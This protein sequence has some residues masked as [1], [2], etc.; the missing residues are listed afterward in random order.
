[1]TDTPQAQD[2]HPYMQR[3]WLRMTAQ[4]LGMAALCGFVVGVLNGGADG[5][6]YGILGAASMVLIGAVVLATVLLHS[7]RRARH[8]GIGLSRFLWLEREVRRVRAPADPALR[9]ALLD[10]AARHREGLDR[11]RGKPYRWL[12]IFLIGLWLV[13]TVFNTL[14]G[15]YWLTVLMLA[16]AL[17]LLLTPVSLRRQ[18]RRLDAVEQSLGHPA[19]SPPS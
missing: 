11:Q 13:N 1:M 2:E 4:L 9:P 7:R 8:F 15:R 14:D 6:L 16:C 17:L 3:Y 5:W 12:R 10:L 19:Q 18:E